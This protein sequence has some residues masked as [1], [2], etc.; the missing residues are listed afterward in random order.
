MGITLRVTLDK[1]YGLGLASNP[2]FEDWE[3]AANAAYE[4]FREACR[5]AIRSFYLEARKQI[6]DPAE[7]D[8]LV[9]ARDALD[10]AMVKRT[11]RDHLSRT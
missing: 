1:E 10:E 9:Q 2:E 7:L 6:T 4:R 5:I 8:D 11:L 3:R